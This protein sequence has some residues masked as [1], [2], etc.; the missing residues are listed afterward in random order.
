M[1]DILRLSAKDLATTAVEPHSKVIGDLTTC[2]QDRTVRLLQVN[3]IQHPLQRQLIEVE[4]IRHIV[5]GADRLG[6]VIDHDGVVALLLDR[7]EGRDTT[8]VKLDRAT[9]VVRSGTKHDH[10]LVPIL[11]G[12]IVTMPIVGQVEVIGLGGILR[13][14]RI[15]LAHHRGDTHTLAQ[16]SDLQL[17]GIHILDRVLEHRTCDLEVGE[18]LYLCPPHQLWRDVADL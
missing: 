5:V 18:A 16:L 13:C 11:K 17:S 6:V 4:P 14:E 7:L 1:V 15:D 3:D 2:R 10:T 8:P 12:D 9:D